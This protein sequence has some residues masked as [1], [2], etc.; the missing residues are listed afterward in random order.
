M[1][2][3]KESS[4]LTT[5]SLGNNVR[6]LSRRIEQRG[7]SLLLLQQECHHD[8]LL[9]HLPILTFLII[10]IDLNTQTI[11]AKTGQRNVI[12]V[13]PPLARLLVHPTKIGKDLNMQVLQ[14]PHSWK[15]KKRMGKIM[16][17]IDLKKLVDLLHLLLKV[18]F[19]LTNESVS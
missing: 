19:M 15:I 3:V 13:F 18:E 7:F 9:Q 14:I 4:T 12:H 5:S 10:L 1:L 17:L 16:E 6:Y 2:V 11:G 8:C